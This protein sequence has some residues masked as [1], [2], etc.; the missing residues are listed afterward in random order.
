MSLFNARNG[1]E[2][3]AKD[4]CL[5]IR[6][7]MDG[8]NIVLSVRDEGKGINTEH[9]SKIGTPFFTTKESGKDLGLLRFPQPM[10]Y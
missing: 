6:T 2:A 9:I 8:Q 4:G 7:F 5:K 1:L 10:Y 3:M